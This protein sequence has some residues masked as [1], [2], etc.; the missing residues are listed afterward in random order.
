MRMM[1]GDIKEMINVMQD[2]YNTFNT[3]FDKLD[4]RF[5][6][7]NERLSKIEAV[8]NTTNKNIDLLVQGYSPITE[9]L[10]SLSED[11][12]VVKFDVDIV[13]KVGTTHSTELKQLR[14]AN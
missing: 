14:K 2:I 13:K 10:N 8:Q 12:E 1:T 11:M 7:M 4:A 9:K 5:V 6:D 3:G